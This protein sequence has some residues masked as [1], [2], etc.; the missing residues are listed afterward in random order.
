MPRIGSQAGR[1]APRGLPALLIG[2]RKGAFILQGDEARRRWALSDPIFL[3]HRVHHLVMDPRDD[4]TLLMACR[5]PGLGPTVF[6]SVDR[7]MS[8]TEASAPP[9]FSNSLRSLPELTIDHVCWLSPGHPREPGVWYAGTSPQGL[10]RSED[11]GVSW[12]GVN[13]FNE[14]PLRIEW[15]GGDRPGATLHSILVDPRDRTHLYIGLSCG[16]VFESFDCGVSWSPLNQG[17]RADFLPVADPA[18]GH[19]P[20]CVQLHPLMPDR[21]YQQNPCGVYRM[22]RSDGRWVRI[23]ETVP[24]E[25]GDVGFPILLHPRD[26]DTVWICPMDGG[27]LWSRV[28]PGGKPALYVTRDGGKSW[29]RQ[30]KGFPT[31]QA[32]W[33]VKRQALTCDDYEP[34]GLYLGTTS[35]EVWGSRTDGNQWSC[36]ARHLPDVESIQAVRFPHE[37]ISLPSA[38]RR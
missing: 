21:L 33:T 27:A 7:G 31:A 6:R 26:P 12:S 9:I 13:G 18:F 23:G 37:T 11:G 14:H 4:H 30:A 8:W 29:A 25:V 32:W 17:C 36:L 19:A 16:G 28:S 3:G 1:P 15:T 34:L 24:A 2:T 20:P 35:G 38:A 5:A 10:F 22:D